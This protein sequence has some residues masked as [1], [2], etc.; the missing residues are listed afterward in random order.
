MRNK[1]EK[2]LRILSFEIDR[3][4]LYGWLLNGLLELLEGGH[5]GN[6]IDEIGK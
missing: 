5:P 4:L 6:G 2:S 3:V 1:K